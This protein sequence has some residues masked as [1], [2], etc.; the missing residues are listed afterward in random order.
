MERIIYTLADLRRAIE[1]LPAGSS[2]TLPRDALL[3]AI[4][5]NGAAPKPEPEQADRLLTVTEVAKRLDV[6]RR[7][8]YGHIDEFPFV[9]RLGPKTLRFSER[10]LDKWLA[11]TK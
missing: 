8:V 4:N 10:G 2:I 1:A 9:R 7:Y 6:S 3:Q 11:R 5:G